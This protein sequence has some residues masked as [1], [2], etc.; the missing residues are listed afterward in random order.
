VGAEPPAYWVI[1]GRGEGGKRSM[2][3]LWFV[4]AK[5]KWLAGAKEK[6]IV[7]GRQ[8]VCEGS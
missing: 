4:A 1:G 3:V 6:M 2:M 5:E 8:G 7:L